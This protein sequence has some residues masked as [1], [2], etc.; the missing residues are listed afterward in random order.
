METEQTLTLYV[1]NRISVIEKFCNLQSF[2]LTILRQ[3][4]PCVVGGVD[5]NRNGNTLLLYFLLLNLLLLH[6]LLLLLELLLLLGRSIV[7]FEL[8]MLLLLWWWLV[9]LLTVVYQ[10]CFQYWCWSL[11]GGPGTRGGSHR[12]GAGG[13]GVGADVGVGGG[14]HLPAGGPLEAVTWPNMQ[15]LLSI[16]NPPP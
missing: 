14:D 9:L 4:F 10:S 6:H 5:F 1:D 11:G 2:I 13:A 12:G 8:H 7:C 3:Y 15:C 16:Y